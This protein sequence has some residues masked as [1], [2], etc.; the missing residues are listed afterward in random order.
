M[1]SN[2][3]PPR[4]FSRLF[5]L[6]MHLVK[7]LPTC[8]PASAASSLSASRWSPARAVLIPRRE[9]AMSP[10]SSLATR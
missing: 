4:I 6:T 7:S 1:V 3:S 5:A 2:H 8:C 10:L 9:P